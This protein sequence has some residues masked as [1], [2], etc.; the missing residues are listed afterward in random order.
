MTADTAPKIKYNEPINLWLHENSQFEDQLYNEIGIIFLL[1]LKKNFTWNKKINYSNQINIGIVRF[2]LTTFDS[3][4]Q[5][6]T[7]WTTFRYLN[8]N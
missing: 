6:S 4:N 7:N 2:E 5:H 1:K 8:K 3:Q